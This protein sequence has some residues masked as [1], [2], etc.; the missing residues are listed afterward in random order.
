MITIAQSAENLNGKKLA[1]E[2]LRLHS[3]CKTAAAEIEA[4]LDIIEEN[5]IEIKK[6]ENLIS[7]L[8]NRIYISYVSEYTE[9]SVLS[10]ELI[11]NESK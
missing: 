10:D 2:I 5:N 6:C 1:S 4:L 3:L 7:A 11:L 9:L 8:Y